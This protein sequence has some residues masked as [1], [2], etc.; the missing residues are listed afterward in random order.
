MTAVTMIYEDVHSLLLFLDSTSSHYLYSDCSVI[1]NTCDALYHV[2]VGLCII[3][4]VS[5]G[6]CTTF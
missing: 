4:T 5:H 3:G 2:R 6:P 1:W